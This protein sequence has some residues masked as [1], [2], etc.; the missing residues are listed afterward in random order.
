MIDFDGVNNKAILSLK[1][2]SSVLVETLGIF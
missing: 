1:S 2:I